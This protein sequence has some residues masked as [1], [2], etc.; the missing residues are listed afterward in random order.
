MHD[1]LWELTV[2]IALKN[3]DVLYRNLSNQHYHNFH[4]GT[5]NGLQYREAI[6]RNFAAPPTLRALRDLR[7]RPLPII[8]QNEVG[9]LPRAR[10]RKG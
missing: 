8:A 6:Q 4:M 5:R 3:E 1:I 7:G 10:V 9:F 2:E